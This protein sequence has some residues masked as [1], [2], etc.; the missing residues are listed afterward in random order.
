MHP[1][2]LETLDERH[3]HPEAEGHEPGDVGGAVVEQRCAQLAP[4]KNGRGR[5]GA[6]SSASVRL[7][8]RDDQL[9]RRRLFRVI[10]PTKIGAVEWQRQEM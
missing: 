4:H 1:S 3:E 8:N 9:Q 6:K 2:H 10:C 5:K 7:Q